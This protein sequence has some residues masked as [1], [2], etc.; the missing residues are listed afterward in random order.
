M[1]FAESWIVVIN[2]PFLPLALVLVCVADDNSRQRA[3]KWKMNG[4]LFFFILFL[5]LLLLSLLVDCC[6]CYYN[7]LMLPT[8][9]FV[10]A[11]VDCLFFV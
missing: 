10:V 3:Q 8:A 9:V 4:M 6:C 1:Y 11:V 5:L 7:F 2:L